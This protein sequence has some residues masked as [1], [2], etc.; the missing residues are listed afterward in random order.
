MT[1]VA[2][3]IRREL[4]DARDA[5]RPVASVRVTGSALQGV[6]AAVSLSPERAA[7]LQLDAHLAEAAVEVLLHPDDY[8]ELRDEDVTEADGVRRVFGVPLIV[9]S[10]L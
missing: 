4:D 8:A 9:D 7:A 2:H 10:P 3:A 1:H 5:E 6:V